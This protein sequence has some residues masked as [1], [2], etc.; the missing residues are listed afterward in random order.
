[1]KKNV[2]VKLSAEFAKRLADKA[3]R[4][5]STIEDL[6]RGAVEDSL[7]EAEDQSVGPNDHVYH[8]ASEFVL[9]RNADLYR[10]LAQ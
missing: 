10:R 7:Q 1:V 9:R 5:G 8:R 6:A 2:T 4:T 3:R